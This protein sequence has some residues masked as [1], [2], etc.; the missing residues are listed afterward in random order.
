MQNPCVGL[1]VAA[2]AEIHSQIGRARERSAAV[3][4]I[5]EDLDEILDLSDRVLVMTAGRIGYETDRAHADRY[6]IGRHMAQGTGRL[7]A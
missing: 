2:V 7:N 6:E 1:D 5:S 4:L 3:L